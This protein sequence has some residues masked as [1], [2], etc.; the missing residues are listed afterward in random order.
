M[1]EGGGGG[2]GEVVSQER[3]ELGWIELELGDCTV[4][5]LQS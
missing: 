2:G 1:G 4:G 3:L 5:Y